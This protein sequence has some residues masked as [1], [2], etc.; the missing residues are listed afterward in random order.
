M[1]ARRPLA[2]LGAQEG[3]GSSGAAEWLTARLPLVFFGAER[4]AP[5]AEYLT[6]V[7]LL[8]FVAAEKGGRGFR[9]VS[10]AQWLC[11]GFGVVFVGPAM[12]PKGKE[13][14]MSENSGSAVVEQM[15]EADLEAEI[16]RLEADVAT[17]TKDREE[18]RK[19]KEAEIMAKYGPGSKFNRQILVGSLDFDE[20]HN[21][22]F[23]IQKCSVC[24]TNV[25][26]FTS[27][28]FQKDKCEEH[29]KEARSA[30]RKG[31]VSEAKKT[32]ADLDEAKAKLAAMKAKLNGSSEEE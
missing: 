31:K 25:K 24:D 23:V 9:L 8:G 14:T 11:C 29:A 12:M 10:A 3:N 26:T 13:I 6:A 17:K 30:R 15:T 18:T 7:L 22:W 2:F 5:F 19:K 21:K 27:D 28:L 16:A 32:A 1:T 4:E 20:D